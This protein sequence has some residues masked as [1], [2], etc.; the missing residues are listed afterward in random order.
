MLY[1]LSYEGGGWR[2][3]GRKLR[4]REAFLNDL[5]D[6]ELDSVDGTRS[7]RRGRPFGRRGPR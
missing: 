2:I 4:S 3:P 1:P 6:E 5:G 7:R